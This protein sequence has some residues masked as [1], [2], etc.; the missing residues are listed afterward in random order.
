MIKSAVFYLCLTLLVLSCKP[1]KTSKLVLDTIPD[2]KT[3]GESYVSNPDNLLSD[4]TVSTLNRDLSALDQEGTAHIDVV[5]VKSIG[6]NVPKDIAHE[7]F[8]KWKIGDQKSNNGLLIFMVKDQKRIEFET[9]YGLEGSL[10]DMICRR[11]QE[12]Y[13]IPY[14]RNNDFDNAVLKG[15]DATISHLKGNAS[16]PA[17]PEVQVVSPLPDQATAPGPVPVMDPGAMR[18]DP[19][20]ATISG[21]NQVQPPVSS[22]EKTG[23]SGNPGGLLSILI[24]VFYMIFAIILGRKMTAYKFK[25]AWLNPFIYLMVLGPAAL[26]IYLNLYYPTSF[27]DLRAFFV[28][29]FL[30]WFFVNAHF[31]ILG[32]ILKASLKEK[33][34]HEQYLAWRERHEPMEK[35]VLKLFSFPFLKAYW[36]TYTERLKRLRYDPM[37]CD[38]CKSTMTLL[39][40]KKEDAY[41]SKGQLTEEQIDAIDYDVWLCTFCN[42]TLVLDY[43]N[44]QSTAKP[45]SQCHFQ[46]MEFKKRKIMKRASSSDDGYG[47]EYYVCANCLF[48]ESIKFIIPQISS[49]SDS[50]SSFSDSSS[51]SSDSSSS[52]SGGDSGGG[53]AGSNW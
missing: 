40:D 19:R 41:L 49:S 15:V 4:A 5:F 29:C 1:S 45:C 30:L 37:D 39:D 53:G 8:R 21:E 18:P 44:L 36:E 31:L 3:L 27:Y 48:E 47:Y 6:D 28:L 43:K 12:D 51:S 34:R 26:I 24:F 50:S 35:I 11:I 25:R 10:P 32:A 17:E 14:A 42:A 20:P 2:P 22:T 7:L 13:M 52:S 23:P 38:H 16:S 33:S 46:T 9:G